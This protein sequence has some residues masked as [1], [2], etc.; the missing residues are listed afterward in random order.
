MML[1]YVDE[2]GD[3]GQFIPG[4]SQNS[5]HFVLSGLIISQE[6]WLSYLQ[7][8]K[9]FRRHIKSQYGLLLKE[10]IH[11]AEL[12]R[13]KKIAAYKQIRKSDRIY[14]LKMF[15][16]QMHVMFPNAKVINIC[17]DK[18]KFPLETDFMTLAWKRLIQRYDT[19]L[20]KSV[21]DKGIIIADDTN[22]DLIRKLIRKMRVYNPVYSHYGGSYQAPTDN[23]LEDPFS[24]DSK[25]SYFI[26]AVDCIAQALYRK[27]FPKGSLKKYG[28]DKIFDSLDPILL[29]EAN[30]KD[31]YGIVRK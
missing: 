30:K 16:Q 15:I 31:D 25:Q 2:S 9:I 28:V 7:N 18:T 4:Y 19:F 23:I 1:M 8:I 12:I 26:Q 5:Q 20:K 13:V 3:V 29:K 22:S 6:E 27:E 14:I 24:R 11:A 21:N 17:L 10:E